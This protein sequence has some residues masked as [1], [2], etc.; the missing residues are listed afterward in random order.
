MRIQAF[1]ERMGTKKK[2]KLSRLL[3]AGV[4][5]LPIAT[6][7]RFWQDDASTRAY[8]PITDQLL[9]DPPAGDWLQYRRT[10]DGNGFRE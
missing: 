2:L 4:V 5:L 10:Y 7:P 9:I 6:L 1:D 3:A 8:Q